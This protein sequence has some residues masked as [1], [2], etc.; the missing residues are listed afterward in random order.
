MNASPKYVGEPTP[1]SLANGLAT[2]GRYGD[3][4]MVHAA[5]GETLVPREILE[6]NPGLK[7]DLF[8]QM[9]MMGVEDPNRYVIGHDL[10]SINPITGQPEFFFKKVWKAIKSVA[11]KALPVIAPI[12]GNLIAPGIGG[13]LASGITTKLMGGSWKDALMAGGLS[14][15][16]GALAQGI[17]GAL[18]GTPVG[19]ALG[20][21]AAAPGSTWA[22]RFAGK[23]GTGLKAP[24]SAASNLFS[25]GAQ[26]PFAQGIFGPRGTGTFFPG[27]AGTEG[28]PSEFAKG[29]IG[30]FPGYQSEAQLRE[31]GIDPKGGGAFTPDRIFTASK[32]IPVSTTD[33]TDP[34]VRN[35]IS[36]ADA[37]LYGKGTKDTLTP[38][39]KEIYVKA[40]GMGATVVEAKK[41]AMAHKLPEEFAAS[42]L[43]HGTPPVS[44]AEVAAPVAKTPQ[45]LSEKLLGD[46]AS[47]LGAMAVSYALSGDEQARADLLSG[48]P[49]KYQ[50]EYKA[51]QDWQ[52]IDDKESDEAKEL[53]KIWYGERAY[54][55]EKLE[56]SF[57]PGVKLTAALD[58]IRSR[59]AAA[60]GEVIGPGTGT[61]DSIPARLS[62]GEFVMTAE[63]VRNAG[64][65]N[66]NLGAA[67][68]YDMMNRF[69]SG[70]A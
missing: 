30:L 67:R 31:A 10:N 29:K 32:R 4:Y 52:K 17:G 2:L 59:F 18:Q 39:G 21:G 28:A 8:R 41:A 49:L 33:L 62:D 70:R 50:K 68:M 61:S 7:D 19:S 35:Y 43:A 3:N 63:A 36:E 23:L 51:Y 14:Y 45:S 11:K 64:N 12:V 58:P 13:I 56:Q 54:T 16:A 34:A 47:G 55:D 38:L 53:K 20:L 37:L 46:A 40:R 69:E 48:N 57:G 66:R 5:E 1:E 6:A 65:G 15:G 25:S 60:G 9:R 26:N 22:G 27:L 44:T 24:L 42:Q